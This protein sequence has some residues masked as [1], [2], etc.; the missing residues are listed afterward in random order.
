MAHFSVTTQI[1]WH[2]WAKGGCYSQCVC[3]GEQMAVLT[4]SLQ[5]VLAHYSCNRTALRWKLIILIPDKVRWSRGSNSGRVFKAMTFCKT[6]VSHAVTCSK[7]TVSLE[8]ACSKFTVSFRVICSKTIVSLSVICLKTIVS[9]TVM[10]SQSYVS[11]TVIC[12]L[13]QFYSDMFKA[14]SVWPWYVHFVSLTVIFS[15]SFAN[16]AVK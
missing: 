7:L 4:L 9:L 10:C 16:H 3:I 2:E 5:V 6:I 15:K 11:L 14:L 13:C 8:L 1:R 12:S